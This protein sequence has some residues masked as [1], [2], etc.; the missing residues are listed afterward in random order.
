VNTTVT[1]TSTGIIESEKT[2]S[3]IHTLAFSLGWTELHNSKNVPIF[4]FYQ[5]YRE[6]IIYLLLGAIPTLI[7]LFTVL[8]KKSKRVF[9][10]IAVLILSIFLS[11]RYGIM[12]IERI[13]Y[14]SDAFRWIS[15]KIW[16]LFIIPI[17]SLCTIFL[18][19]IPKIKNNVFKHSTFI[20]LFLVL[21][22]FSFPI[23]SGNLLSSQTLVQI[24]E[25]YFELPEESKI[26][27]LPEPQAL[28]MRE[29]DWDYYG[30]DFFSYIN[31]SI[32]V[33]RAN[34]YETGR[35]Y[36]EILET[37]EIP[38]D[39]EYILYDNTVKSEN[40]YVQ[41]LSDFKIFKSNTH[42]TLYER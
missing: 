6:N 34:L 25:E 38:T 39:I 35:E 27:I 42:Y 11:S 17:I 7:A 20:L 1:E 22:I 4:E 41:F 21:T 23:L 13:P 36:N 19:D 32:F 8:K 14:F 40:E 24:P 37:R 33:D 9:Y 3:I 12:V 16:P 2:N 31:S 29:Y 5:M 18:D 15:S 10:L 30:S 28:Y 26:L